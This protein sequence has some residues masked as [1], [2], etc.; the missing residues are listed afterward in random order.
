MRLL[1]SWWPGRLRPLLPAVTLAAAFALAACGGSDGRLDPS[2][3]PTATLP[4]QLPA[5]TIIASTPLPSEAGRTYTVQ[6]GDSPA[7]IAEQ[8]GVS[9]EELMEA[10][11]IVDPTGLQVGQVLT[12]PGEVTIGPFPTPVSTQPTP[13]PLA[14]A[15]TPAAGETS[16]VVQSGDNT[17]DIAD[18]FGVTIEELAAA[19]NATVDELRQLQVGDVLIIPTVAPPSSAPETQTATPTP[20]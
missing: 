7:S 3:V 12:I 18:R 2:K 5:P 16:Y 11:S 6:P 4:A 13:S 1:K 10:N 20:P 15:A 14:G 8:F 19:N 9:V 17:S